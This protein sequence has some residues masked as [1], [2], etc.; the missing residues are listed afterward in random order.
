M[1]TMTKTS[2]LK[3][4]TTALPTAANQTATVAINTII[5]GGKVADVTINT[6][7]AVISNLGAWATNASEALLREQE[8]DQI[9]DIAVENEVL[10]NKLDAKKHEVSD[11]EMTR[12]T[13][14]FEKYNIPVPTR[15]QAFPVS[16]GAAKTDII[17]KETVDIEMAKSIYHRYLDS[18]SNSVNTR[19]KTV[20]DNARALLEQRRKMK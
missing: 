20:L 4:I 11:E 17:F 14:H 1:T 2:L 18:F 16:S 15:M 5:G 3:L 7:V 13:S 9:V 8:Q 6:G 19:N 12:V 10:S